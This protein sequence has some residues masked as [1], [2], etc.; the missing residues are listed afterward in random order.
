MT[1]ADLLAAKAALGVTWERLAVALGYEP[2]SG[3]R[4]LSAMAAGRRPIPTHVA[5]RIA[6]ML[7]SKEAKAVVGL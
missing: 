4:A 7:A 3:Q 1:P 5:Q 6:M 2:A